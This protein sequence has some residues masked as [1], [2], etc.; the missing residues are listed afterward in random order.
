LVGRVVPRAPYF[1]GAVYLLVDHATGSASE[2]LAH[3]LKVTRRATVVGERTLGAML[4]GPPRALQD[5]WLVTI[6]EADFIT[7]DGTR[8]EGNGVE[9]NIEAAPSEVF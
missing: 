3:F 8:I 7:A 9:P 6:P 1:A 5:G 4:M 2:P